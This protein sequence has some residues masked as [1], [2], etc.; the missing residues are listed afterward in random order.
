MIFT[1]QSS[2]SLSELNR[3]VRDV[4]R[5]NFPDTYWVRAETSDV[6]Q[7]RSGH[8]YL[9]FIEKDPV[10]QAILA[11]SRGTIWANTF[12]MLSTYFES[13]T[14]QPFTSGLKVLVRVS[15]EFHEIYGFSLN[16]VDID[17]TFTLGEMAKNRLLVLKRL[18]EEG[19]LTLNKE[20]P[21]PELCNRI[22]VISSP[23]AAGYEDFCD[24]LKKN[25]YG[26]VFY[27][28]LFPAI[29]QGEKSE[30]S[31]IAALERI[32]AYRHLFDAVAIIRGGGATS[33]LNCFDSYVLATHCA[34]FPLPIVVG[35]GHERDVTVLDIVAHTR[36]KTPTA[37]AEFFIDHLA[38][39]FT[40]LVDLEKRLVTESR[41]YLQQEKFKLSMLSKEVYHFST[42][43]IRDR[44]ALMRETAF[45]LKHLANRTIQ[46]LQQEEKQRNRQFA[47]AVKQRL[48][49]EAHA[50]L[51]NE[52]YIR[53]VSPENILK[54]GYTITMKTGKIVTSAAKLQPDDMIETL[55]WDGKIESQVKKSKE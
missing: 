42:G 25:P 36:A 9:E 34:Q 31:I 18:E 44:L 52:Q 38:G 41:E 23:T 51:V 15:V 1:Q 13:E 30:A 2:V 53:M 6:R 32:Y 37:V 10:T 19:V 43:F 12:Q 40:E 27:T 17:P 21:L 48:Q 8:C 14:G 55:F 22:A 50:L 7:N 29:M 49:N 46:F 24:Q 20:L 16:V 11:R 54:R 33:E 45:R 28:K 4:I 26:L 5:K 3:L 39:S 35:I 47:H